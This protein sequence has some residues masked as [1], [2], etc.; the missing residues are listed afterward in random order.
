MTPEAAA[1]LA[2]S[3]ALVLGA[4]SVLSVLLGYWRSATVGK[5]GALVMGT[6]VLLIAVPIFEDITLEALGMK[7]QLGERIQREFASD[8]EDTAEIVTRALEAGAASTPA[9][10]AAIA[11]RGIIVGSAMPDAV[12]A[13]VER[14]AK[15]QNDACATGA[16]DCAALTRNLRSLTR[17][18]VAKTPRDVLEYAIEDRPLAVDPSRIDPSRLAP[19]G[20]GTERSPG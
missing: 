17:G 2:F 1:G 8:P 7:L 6:G 5:G 11:R 14:L 3:V 10:A 18:I 20:P 16:A 4:V 9:V 19:L 12:V 15:Q 13:S